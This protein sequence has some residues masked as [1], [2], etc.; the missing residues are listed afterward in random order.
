MPFSG[1]QFVYGLAPTL[2]PVPVALTATAVIPP[3]N[4][5]GWF[6]K[7]HSGGTLAVVNA[8]SGLT[9]A[10]GFI[11]GASMTLEVTGP[12]AFF[13]NA[14]GATA[15]AAVMFKRSAGYSNTVG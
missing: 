6:L 7:Q 1:D 13:L 8:A 4:C 9:A 2:I 15:V 3:A 5:N 11:L 10:Q 14:G 12:A